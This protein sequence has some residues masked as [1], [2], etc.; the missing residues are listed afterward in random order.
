M[1]KEIQM[2]KTIHPTVLTDAQHEQVANCINEMI[3]HGGEYE[4]A[5][6]FAYRSMTSRGQRQI[7]NDL[8]YLFAMWIDGG[9]A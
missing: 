2:M 4:Q 6:A 1:P 8:S 9:L 3:R 7:A 5:I